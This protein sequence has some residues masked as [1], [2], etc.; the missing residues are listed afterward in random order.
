MVAPRFKSVVRFSVQLIKDNHMQ[1]A[2]P[3]IMI[4]E[5][6]EDALFLLK[7]AL[8]EAGYVVESSTGRSGIVNIEHRWPDLFILDKNFSKIDGIDISKFLRA[9]EVTRHTPIVMISAWPLKQ[10]AK[11]AG[12]DEFIQKPFDI[13]RL[14]EVLRKYTGKL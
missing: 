8:T 7:K 9:Q 3:R 14:L 1:A 5:E 2:A 13:N 6:D 12:V 11:L 10:K 4:I